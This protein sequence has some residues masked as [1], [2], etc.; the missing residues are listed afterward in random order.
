MYV[1]TI[2]YLEGRLIG[3]GSSPWGTSHVKEPKTVLDSGF[4]VLD[5]G[6]PVRRTFFPDFTVSLIELAI[7]KTDSWLSPVLCNL[8]SHLCL[9]K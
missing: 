4:Q 9:E 6:F 8:I 5:S 7:G 2:E 1:G 3:H